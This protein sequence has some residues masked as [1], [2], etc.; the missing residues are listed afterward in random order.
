MAFSQRARRMKECACL[1]TYFSKMVRD[2][3]EK[4]QRRSGVDIVSSYLDV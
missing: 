4:T 2:M 3:T 1:W